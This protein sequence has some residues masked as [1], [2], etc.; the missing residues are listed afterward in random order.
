MRT[1][2]VPEMVFVAVSLPIHALVTL[3]PGAKMS[4]TEPK[5]EKDAMLSETVEAPTVFSVGARA[6]LVLL[7]S[8]ASL[9]AAT[10]IGQ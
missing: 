9:P 7:A 6:G 10:Y 4:T 2:D 1:M 5:L 3:V 8:E